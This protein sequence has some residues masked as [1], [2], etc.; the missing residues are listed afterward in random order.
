MV[1]EASVGARLGGV[2]AASMV[3]DAT[4]PVL[5]GVTEIVLDVHATMSRLPKPPTR[6]CPARGVR[7]DQ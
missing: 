2:A 3:G 7:S 1:G 4:T 6:S 5:V